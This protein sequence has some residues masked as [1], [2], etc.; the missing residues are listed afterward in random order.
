MRRVGLVCQDR[1][2]W[3]IVRG[4]D[5]GRRRLG[6]RER[7]KKGIYYPAANYLVAAISILEI[8]A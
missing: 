3:G 4:A 1:C 6:G 2:G 7:D 5:K 8:A